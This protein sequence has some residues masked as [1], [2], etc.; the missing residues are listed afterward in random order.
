M[1]TFSPR[2]F[3]S[4]YRRLR[5]ACTS[6]RNLEVITH[7]L[8]SC[9]NL[10]SVGWRGNCRCFVRFFRIHE[11]DGTQ[12]SRNRPRSCSKNL[13]QQRTD[14]KHTLFLWSAKKKSSAT[15]PVTN[16]CPP[17]L[18]SITGVVMIA[19]YN[20]PSSCML[21]D[22]TGR[23]GRARPSAQEAVSNSRPR[24]PPHQETRRRQQEEEPHRAS[25]HRRDQQRPRRRRQE[26]NKARRRAL[27]AR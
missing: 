4:E 3:F 5:L 11:T 22:V 27:V 25:P 14:R 7:E 18:R 24:P 10:M 8:C 9:T 13:Y 12:Q 1:L 19:G 15:L 20:S 26:A 23:I 21:R 16:Q 2:T 6:T 17:N